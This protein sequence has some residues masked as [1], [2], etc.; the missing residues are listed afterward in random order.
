M[1]KNWLYFLLKLT[2]SCVLIIYILSNFQVEQLFHRL[3]DI[4]LWHLFSATM[5]FVLLMFNNTLR[6]YIVINAIGSA[7]PY[8]TSFKIFYIGLFFNQ[9]LPS[10]VGGDAVRMYLANKEGL[11]LTSAINSVLL[12]RIATL[13][14][15]I[16][17]VVICQPLLTSKMGGDHTQ[18]IFP[19]LFTLSVT[20]IICLMFLDRLPEK[21]TRFRIL[22]GI[23]TLGR[24]A[25][26]LFLSP[27]NAARSIILGITGNI[28]LSLIVFLLSQSLFLDL[29][30]LDCLVLIPPVVLVSTIPIS[31]AGWGVREAAMITLLALVGVAEAD[32]FVLSVLFGLLT[33]G[34]SL[35]GG[36]VWIIGGYKVDDTR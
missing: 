1:K 7:L 22:A 29:S 27:A 25:K 18:L 35:P 5:I 21:L 31:I 3:E 8:K 15:L 17:L 14:G 26:K 32:A 33:F 6:W 24:S 28:I 9:T 30:F 4:E 34:L 10:S 19:L 12:E 2:V 20:G 13:L 16:I 23:S 36:I 11:S